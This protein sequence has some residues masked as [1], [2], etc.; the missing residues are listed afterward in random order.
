MGRAR[1]W[2]EDSTIRVNLSAGASVTLSFK[3]NLFDLS[4]EER[5]L[6]SDLSLTVQK[7]QKDSKAASVIVKEG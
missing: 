7:Y 2:G 5:T 6:V 3:G 1:Q 4:P